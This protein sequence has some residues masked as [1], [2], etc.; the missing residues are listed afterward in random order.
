MAKARKKDFKNRKFTTM[1][2][3][4][5]SMGDYF[6]ES[7]FVNT[8]EGNLFIRHDPLLRVAKDPEVL[9]G[10]L[11]KETQVVQAPEKS[12]EWCATVIVS[13]TFHGTEEGKLGG[14]TIPLTFS[15]TGDSRKSNTRAGYERYST[16]MAET[17]A[18][19]RAL[20]FALGVEFCSAEEIADLDDMI[21]ESFG[22]APDEAQLNLF[23]IKITLV[24]LIPCSEFSCHSVLLYLKGYVPVSPVARS[25]CILPL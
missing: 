19:A 24:F 13:Y 5:F 21:D 23:K 14:G 12:N 8:K 1:A 2:G 17:R 4:I 22:E 16:A 25:A 18:S 9:G 6:Q 7:D 3:D 11:K 10:L 15:G 20:R